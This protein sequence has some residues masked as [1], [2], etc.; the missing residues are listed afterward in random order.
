M[1]TFKLTP[2]PQ[3]DYRLEV[4]EIQ[5]ECRLEKY[6][7]RHN[8]VVYGFCDHLPDLT[9]LQSRGLKIEEIPFDDARRGLINDLVERGRAKSKVDHLKSA[10]EETGTQNEQEEAA[11]QQKLADLNNTI[12]AAKEA[13]G[14]TGV[15]KLLKF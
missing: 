5:K 8:K 13:L 6:G 4:A 12:Q 11:T 14:I 7:Y 9:E 2:K 15:L 1:Q 10:R 3:R